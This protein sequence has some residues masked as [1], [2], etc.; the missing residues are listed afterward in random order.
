MEMIGIRKIISI[1]KIQSMG[2]SWHVHLRF[3][4]IVYLS[5]EKHKSLLRTEAQRNRSS[6]PKMSLDC[7]LAFAAP[8]ILLLPQLLPFVSHSR[9]P[10]AITI[11]SKN[12]YTHTCLG[13]RYGRN[14]IGRIYAHRTMARKKVF[15]Q[16]SF[17][18]LT[19]LLLHVF[20]L[21]LR[22]SPF[23]IRFLL[24]LCS[25]PCVCV[26]GS[27]WRK[28]NRSKHLDTILSSFRLV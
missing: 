9:L 25:W 19:I 13:H 6:A 22:F 27:Q 4:L 18:M 26:C 14:G 15:V 3:G 24:R 5:L 17:L 28:S 12:G 10:N 20:Y 7:L 2:E 1:R 8:T 11:K 16:I 23:V 21:S